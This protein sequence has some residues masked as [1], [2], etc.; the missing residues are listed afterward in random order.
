MENTSYVHETIKGWKLQVPLNR[1]LQ[2]CLKHNSA[3][4][5]ETE[6]SLKVQKCASLHPLLSHET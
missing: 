1:L 5:K 6:G 4:R 2:G 3:L